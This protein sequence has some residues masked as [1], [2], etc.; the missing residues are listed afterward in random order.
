[1]QYYVYQ[2]DIVPGAEDL[3]TPMQDSLDLERAVRGQIAGFLVPSFILDLPAEG[4]KR[5]TRGVESYDHRIGLSKLTAPGLKGEPVT[6]EYWDPL[7]SLPEDGRAEVLAR[8][9][10]KKADVK[11]AN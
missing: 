2:G 10:N 7:W 4:G 11:E 9:G 5:L 1:V 3:R 6:M 8:F